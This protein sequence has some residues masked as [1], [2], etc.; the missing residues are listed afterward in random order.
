LIDAVCEEA[1]MNHRLTGH[2]GWLRALLVLLAAALP[3]AA[4]AVTLVKSTGPTI[5]TEL[6]RTDG[7][8]NLIWEEL[9]FTFLLP[10]DVPTGD[11]IFH[12]YA[13][14]DINNI[15]VDWVDVTT[16]PFGDR[17][18]L[19]TFAFPIG[20]IHFTACENPPHTNP[21]ACP[22]PEN[23]P[24]GLHY[25]PSRGPPVGDVQGR[26]NTSMFSAGTPGLIVPQEVIEPGTSMIVS[27]FPRNGIYDLYIDRI[28]LTYPA[29]RV[30]IPEP[31]TWLTMLLGLGG[32]A[33]VGLRRRRQRP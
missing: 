28:E 29:A 2:R 5:K 21:N 8:S 18:L 1:E 13:G 16:G 11:G 22:V 30:P 4:A 23:V 7:S 10:A 17:T 27:L 31:S 14:G 20:D 33:L 9:A 6:F 3:L 24:G 25:D 12:M 19:G 26:R 32:I 15:G